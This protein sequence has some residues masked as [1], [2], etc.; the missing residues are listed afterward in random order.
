MMAHAVADTL[1]AVRAW[2]LPY[3]W[4]PRLWDWPLWLALG[5]LAL[6]LLWLLLALW[7]P[8]RRWRERRPELLVSRGVLQLVDEEGAT[9]ENLLLDDEDAP[10]RN[11][12]FELRACVSNL[13]AF[14][15]QLLEISVRTELAPEPSVVE[16]AALL[17]PHGVVDLEADLLG[18]TGEVGMLELYFYAANHSRRSYRLRVELRWEPWRGCYKVQPLAQLIE[19]ARGLPSSRLARRQRLLWREAQAA[20]RAPAAGGAAAAG[21]LGD[22]LG[23]DPRAAPHDAGREAGRDDAGPP[24][25]PNG[26][27]QTDDDARTE[28]E[29][30]QFPWDF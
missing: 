25:G 17:P 14:P 4:D 13:S 15:V 10:P 7:R 24:A 27:K 23:D 1:A 6:L 19:P 28:G 8:R 11:G 20:R 21:N 12:R 2:L 9:L 22:D 29:R 30:L 3:G 26:K 18:L 5:S 16:V